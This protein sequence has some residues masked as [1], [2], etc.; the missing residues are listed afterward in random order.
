MLEGTQECT[1]DAMAAARKYD[2][3]Q[4]TQGGCPALYA[5]MQAYVA[6]T[7]HTCAQGGSVVEEGAVGVSVVQMMAT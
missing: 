5:L 1:V 2:V 7:R 6:V 4:P 3:M